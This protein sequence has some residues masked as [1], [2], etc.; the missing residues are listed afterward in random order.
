[1]IKPST[2]DIKKA[3]MDANLTQTQAAN[4]IH[5]SFGAWQKWERGRRE[6]HPAFFELFC[7]K[8]N[9]KDKGI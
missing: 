5:C 7:I 8:T 4:L 1:M 6:M 2:S 9:F 3:R